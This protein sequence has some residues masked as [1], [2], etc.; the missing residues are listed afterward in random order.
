[1]KGKSLTIFPSINHLDWTLQLAQNLHL[2]QVQR[3]SLKDIYTCC[4]H[5]SDEVALRNFADGVTVIG[6]VT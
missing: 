2:L 1:M 4:K 5:I 6:E 3:R